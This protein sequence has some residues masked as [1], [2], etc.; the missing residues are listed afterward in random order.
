M[1]QQTFRTHVIYWI[2]PTLFTVICILIY[3]FDLFGASEI[4]SPSFNREFGILENLQALLI[5]VIVFITARGARLKQ[6][7]LEKYIFYLIAVLSV[8]F[9]LEELDYGLHFY[10]L[11]TGRDGDEKVYILY[12]AEK[13]RNIHNTGKNTNILKMTSYVIIV[14][15]FVLLPILKQITKHNLPII[16]KITP[17]VYIIYTVISLFLLNQFAFYLYRQDFHT[18][19]SL[20]SNVSEF[21]ELMF[22]YIVLLYIAKMAGFNKKHHIT[23]V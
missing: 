16:H 12:K 23:D 2:L 17:S 8:F 10:E 3:F 7:K 1:K 4:I 22:Y 14:L 9:F 18:N 11:I 6:N 15:F 19:R 20:D 13:I 21:E 5:L